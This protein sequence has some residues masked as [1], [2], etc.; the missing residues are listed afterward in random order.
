M[1]VLVCGDRNWNDPW[2]IYDVLS[3][4]NKDTVIIHGGARGAD[5]M[6]GTVANSLG[7]EVIV[8][9]AEWE[10]FNKSLEGL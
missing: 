10:K 9:K 3:K 8:I 7:L 1:R 4:L 5:T 2:V 6:A